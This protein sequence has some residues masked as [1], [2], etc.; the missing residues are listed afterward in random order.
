MRSSRG[1]R[2]S[3]ANPAW[4]R[5][6]CTVVAPTDIPSAAI[7]RVMSATERLCSLRNAITRSFRFCVSGSALPGF[8]PRLR[9][10][11]KADMSG[12][13]LKPVQRLR[14]A[15][16]LYPKRLATASA[17]RPSTKW[18]LR[19]SYCLWVVLSGSRKRPM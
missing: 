16:G 5:M 17:V 18:A 7:C 13:F 3:L 12:F 11:K 10:T 9:A 2:G 6:R 8:G 15:P 1:R 19:A 14:K 4:R